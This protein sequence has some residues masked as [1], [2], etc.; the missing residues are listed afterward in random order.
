MAG[1]LDGIRILDFGTFLAG[2]FANMMMAQMGA[3]VIKVEAPKKPDGARFFCVAPGWPTPDFVTGSQFFNLNNM[4][5]KSLVLDLSTDEGKEII[6]DIAKDVDIIM[7][8]MKPGAIDKVG[9][10]YERVKEVNPDIIFISSS[11]C[12]DTG[13][14]RDFLGYASLFAAKVGL[15]HAT[16]YPDAKPSSFVGPIDSR[17]AANSILAMLACLLHRQA[18]GEGQFVDISSQEAV[19]AQLGD[20]YLDAEVNQY[21][22]MRC[23]NHRESYVPNNAYAT[24]REDEWVTISIRHDQ[25]EEW[26]ELCKVMER[27][28]LYRAYPDHARRAAHQAEIDEAITA[29]TRT[30]NNYD[31]MELLQKHGIPSGVTL[32]GRDYL[33]N[34]HFL[35]REEFS[36]VP[37]PYLGE[38]CATTACWRFSETPCRAPDRA[39]Y[40]GEHTEEI[41]RDCAHLSQEKIDDLKARKQII[42]T[43]P[44]T[45]V[46]RHNPLEVQKEKERDEKYPD[47]R[48]GLK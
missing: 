15:S 26:K 46:I 40:F 11:A 5:K 29:W 3:E 37:H 25:N 41:L 20:I 42:C 6:L 4:Y 45:Y 16:G 30:R 28:D 7:E 43:D 48:G 36:F 39:P 21:D 24:D 23:G 10:S 13:P 47:L 17:S 14:E 38:D 35:A 31:I 44:A 9:L 2:P 12:G 27:E 18:T 19:A 1:I 22:P 8:N 32:H 33:N 34:P